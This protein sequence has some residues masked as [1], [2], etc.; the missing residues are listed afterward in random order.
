MTSLGIYSQPLDLDLTLVGP[1]LVDSLS[2]RTR[3]I[4]TLW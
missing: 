4:V 1:A 3:G 2:G